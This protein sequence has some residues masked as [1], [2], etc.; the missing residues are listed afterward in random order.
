MPLPGMKTEWKILF[1]DQKKMRSE[2]AE[3]TRKRRSADLQQQ[4][5]E[6]PVIKP[7]AEF[8][9]AG[10][11]CPPRKVM[12]AVLHSDHSPTPPSLCPHPDLFPDQNINRL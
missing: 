5:T 2:N 4:K 9:H 3:N 10:Y 1:R 7:G 8:I 12:H 11:R 6:H